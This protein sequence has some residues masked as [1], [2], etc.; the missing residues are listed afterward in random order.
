[1]NDV[2]RKRIQRKLENLPDEVVYQVVDYIDFLERKYGSEK[3]APTPLQK[4]AEG[5][6]DVLRA[7][8]VPVAAIKGTMQAVDAAGRM[9]SGVSAAGK[10]VVDEIQKV[11]ASEPAEVEQQQA[12]GA[13][14]EDAAPPKEEAS[15]EREKSEEGA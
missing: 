5:V 10:A 9:M 4:L 12:T 8:K 14:S 3:F 7:G 1:M 13:N 6:E 2:M 11:A 15:P